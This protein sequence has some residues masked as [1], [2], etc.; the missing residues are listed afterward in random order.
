ML[1]ALALSFSFQSLFGYLFSWIGL[2]TA[3]F[4]G[5]AAAGALLMSRHLVGRVGVGRQ[6]IY[7]ELAVLLMALLLPVMVPGIGRILEQ[8]EAVA[9]IRLLFLMLPFICGIVTGAQFPLAARLRREVTGSIGSTAG[10]LY[11]A[12]LM[13]GWLGGMLGGVLLLPVLGL[14]GTGVSVALLK[15]LTLALFGFSLLKIGRS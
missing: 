12:D 10:A 11:A 3:L 6:M 2:L 14:G 7:S 9:L 15:L 8:T 1:F 5:G 4:M 13:G